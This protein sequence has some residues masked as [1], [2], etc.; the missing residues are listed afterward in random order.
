MQKKDLSRVN[1]EIGKSCIDG[2]INFID[3]NIEKNNI[4]ISIL[5]E[6]SGYSRR[7]LQL[8]FRKY[9]RMSIGKYIKLRKISRASIYLLLTNNKISDISET[10]LFDSPQTFSREFKKITGVSPSQYRSDKSWGFLNMT[11]QINTGTIMPLPVIK[12]IPE[13]KV[14]VRSFS[15]EIKIGCT[16]ELHGS[17]ND[18]IKIL[19]KKQK[20]IISYSMEP[21]D[22]MNSFITNS[23]VWGKRNDCDKEIIINSG[24][25]AYFSYKG[26][27]KNYISFMNNVYMNVLGKFNFKKKGYDIEIIT[28]VKGGFFF[29]YYLP[30]QDAHK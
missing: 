5:S 2:V 30:I 4:T 26:S 10:M 27:R 12:F 24:R 9:I 8:L 21:C 1:I 14:C 3:D 7:H 25:F 22:K 6:Y 13:M 28:P 29:E 19:H 17:W 11:G 16:E 18:I 23:F 20:A 15:S